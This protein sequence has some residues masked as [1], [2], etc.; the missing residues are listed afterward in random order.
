ML[1]RWKLS[2][3]PFLLQADVQSSRQLSA[4][5]QF[6]ACSAI[7]PTRVDRWVPDSGKISQ[8]DRCPI[9][10]SM[11]LNPSRM[12]L[13]SEQGPKT[14]PEISQIGR[15]PIQH[16]MSLYPSRME[17]VSEQCPKTIP[18]TAIDIQN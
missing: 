18:D 16:I 3:L 15:C 9:Q 1:T 8:I 4:P 11:S 17:L 13:V 6:D 5:R 10:Q 12:E 7:I 14:I 2:G